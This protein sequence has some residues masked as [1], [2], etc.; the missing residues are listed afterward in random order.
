LGERDELEDESFGQLNY[1]DLANIP[2]ATD[3]ADYYE[4]IDLLDEND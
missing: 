1:P 4:L 3:A 2:N